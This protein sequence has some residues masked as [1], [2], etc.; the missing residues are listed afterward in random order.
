MFDGMFYSVGLALV[1]LSICSTITQPTYRQLNNFNVLSKSCHIMTKIYLFKMYIDFL[2]LQ[3]L[4]L[5]FIYFVHISATLLDVYYTQMRKITTFSREEK[6]THTH[7]I[8]FVYDDGV[9]VVAMHVT[10]TINPGCLIPFTQFMLCLNSALR[11]LSLCFSLFSTL[12][13]SSTQ[14]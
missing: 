8:S 12:L 3:E 11:F 1:K 9:V 5:L 4:L 10:C 13:S 7:T 2:F 6:Y 14:P